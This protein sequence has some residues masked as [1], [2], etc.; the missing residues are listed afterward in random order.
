MNRECDVTSRF[1][2][3]PGSVSESQFVL[4]IEISKIRSTRVRKAL[5]DYFVDGCSIADVC[6]KHLLDRCYFYRKLKFF[7]SLND[8]IVLLSAYY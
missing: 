2:L 4:L 5:R 1:E 8:K 7:H 6:M 3:K